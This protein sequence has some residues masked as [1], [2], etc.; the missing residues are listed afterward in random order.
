MG[1][2]VPAS[3]ALEFGVEYASVVIFGTATLVEEEEQAR[4]ALQM[5][6]D[7]YCPHL[8]P[9]EHYRPIVSDELD[10]TAVYRIT[11]ETWSAKEARSPAEAPGAFFYHPED[12]SRLV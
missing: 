4:R 9:G 1:R 2:L 6:L 7:K 10:R 11:I 12:P 8:R 3:T 5:V